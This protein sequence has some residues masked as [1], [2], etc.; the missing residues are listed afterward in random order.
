MKVSEL[1]RMLRH[2]NCYLVEHGREHDK[3]HSDITER[4]FRVPRHMAKELPTGTANSIL[5]DAG[6]R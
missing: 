4:D 2:N 1:V 5:K 3:W 6:L